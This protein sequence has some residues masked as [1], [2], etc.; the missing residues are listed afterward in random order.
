MTEIPKCP[1]CR[2]QMEFQR[3]DPGV[4]GLLHDENG[5]GPRQMSEYRQLDAK[6]RDALELARLLPHGAERTKAMKE[7]SK[8]RI[9]ADK[10]LE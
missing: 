7:A 5:S 2:A 1:R 3:I 6:A 10:L 8:L 9:A 4:R